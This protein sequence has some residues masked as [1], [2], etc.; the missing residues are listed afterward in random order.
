[1]R[2]TFLLPLTFLLTLA[3]PAAA[4]R[5]PAAP[6]YEVSGQL[7]NA[8]AGTWVQVSDYRDGRDVV[9]DSARTDAAGRF[10]VR[11]RV[12]APGVYSL[13][14][15]G[16][17]ATAGLALAPGS[18]LRVRAD[19]TSLWL[20]GEVSGSSAAVALAEMNREHAR[21]M[22]RIEELAR[23]PP[24]VPADTAAQ[25]R[26]AQEWSAHA[27]ALTAAAKRVARQNSFVAPYAAMSFLSGA[28]YEADQAFVDSATT[29]Y[30]RQWPELSYTRRLL[31][32]QA[33]RRA[34]AIGQP[35]PDVQLPGPDGQPQALSSL[36]GQYVLLDFWASWCGPCRQESP[37]LVKLHRQYQGRGFAVYGI[38]VDSKRE[39][40]TAALAQDQLPGAQV[41]DASGEASVAGT[42]YNVYE[43]PT[44]FLL[45]RQGRII[46]KNLK[47]EALEKK[48]AELLP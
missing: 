6:N 7:R 13:R 18:H 46:A 14:V 36:R 10:R 44:S 25:R 8:P 1:M 48:L 40:W 9:L 27:A 24:P 39:A 35:A 34:T 33:M 4:Q 28:A 17:R 32:Y 42:K 2:P 23:R 30:A 38:S 12:A 26:V 29:R 11:G 22:G 21:I 16:Q 20:T 5:R 19:A 47:G 31:Q 41:L 15:P 3:V 45:D 43:Y 37:N